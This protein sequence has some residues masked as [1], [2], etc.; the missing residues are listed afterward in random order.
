MERIRS[1]GAAPLGRTADEP[2]T[3]QPQPPPPLL[4]GPAPAS[5]AGG[6]DDIVEAIAGAMAAALPPP[7][8][9]RGVPAAGGAERGP[10]SVAQPEPAKQARNAAAAAAAAAPHDPT[11]PPPPSLSATAPL[12]LAAPGAASAA[13]AAGPTAS[14]RGSSA[15]APGSGAAPAAA[16]AV[17]HSG[18][19]GS[20]V[21]PLAPPFRFAAVENGVLRGAYPTLKNFRFLLRYV[22]AKGGGGSGLWNMHVSR[23]AVGHGL[24]RHRGSHDIQVA[25]EARGV[26]G[27]RASYG[28][29]RGILRMRAH[30]AIAFQGRRRGTVLCLVWFSPRHRSV[31]PAG[32]AWAHMRGLLCRFASTT[33]K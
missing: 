33:R 3:E 16:L 31:Q 14:A 12:P 32:E 11:L 20:A 17:V 10:S 24:W 1:V 7:R 21:G 30:R 6:G 18:L 5:H 26:S 22:Q 29:S 15:G 2:P 23:L 19:S 4:P 28:G 9:R 27:A 25:V 8:R 13:L